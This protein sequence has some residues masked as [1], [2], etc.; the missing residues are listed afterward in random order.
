MWDNIGDFV[1]W[2]DD[3]K[4]GDV[5]CFSLGALLK[6]LSVGAGAVV[7]AKCYD[8]NMSQR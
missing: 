4:V 8:L 6:G 5:G 3:W 7:M 1:T 2:G